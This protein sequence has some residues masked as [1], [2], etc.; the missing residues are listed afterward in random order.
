MK[1]IPLILISAVALC[2]LAFAYDMYGGPQ[3][4]PAPAEDHKPASLS[5]GAVP[6]FSFKTI[7]GET[8]SIDE[9]K[10]KTI[11]INFWATWC[12]PCLVE[13]PDMLEMIKSYEGDVILLAISSDNKTEDITR[14]TAKQSASMKE[15]LNSG[16]VYITLDENR[17]ITHDLFLT[18]RY[19]ETIIV[20]PNGEMVRKI[21]GPLDW[22]N[23][24][25]NNYLDTLVKKN[26]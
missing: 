25:I 1:A 5:L 9:L 3:F 20:A 26:K 8:H 16:A 15:T 13:F 23:S 21:V 19:P 10:G 14:F 17:T 12:A 24:E 6:D 18:E 11:I 2:A 7:E 22:T 4:V